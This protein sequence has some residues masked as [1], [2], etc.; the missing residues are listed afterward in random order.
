MPAV[1]LGLSD[2]PNAGDLIYAVKDDKTAKTISEKML[3]LRE[4]KD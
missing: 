2:V 4:T 3:S 1:I